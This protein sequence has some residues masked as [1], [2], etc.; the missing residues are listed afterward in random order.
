[1]YTIE[2]DEVETCFDEALLKAQISPVLVTLGGK[3]S[4]VIVS[5]EDF[6]ATEEMKH[7]FLKKQIELGQEDIKAGRI[8]DGKKAF[9]TVLKRKKAK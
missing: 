6:Q 5:V 1:M 9:D 3:P 8:T 2:A 4:A 7:Q